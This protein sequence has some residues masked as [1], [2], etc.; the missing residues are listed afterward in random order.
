MLTLE[1]E[2]IFL[3][4]LAAN[5]FYKEISNDPINTKIHTMFR[6]SLNTQ[7]IVFQPK[8]FDEHINY[9]RYC[10]GVNRFGLR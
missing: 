1:S 10:I 7:K 5:K 2:N 3:Y 9:C 6:C 8:G 4:N